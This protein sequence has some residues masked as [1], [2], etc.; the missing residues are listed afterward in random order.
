MANLPIEWE[1]KIN[2]PE[3]IAFLKQFGEKHYLSA[4]EINQLRDGINELDTNLNNAI[5]NFS[6]PTQIIKS[7]EVAI[8]GLNISV[9]AG[10]FAWK[11]NN[12]SFLTPP[13][14]SKTLDA[15]TT[16][17]YR[18]DLLQGNSD[19]TYSIK[20]SAES[21]SIGTPP[22]TDEGS[23]ALSSFL[24]FGE[25]VS[26][27]P[28]QPITGDIYLKKEY[29]T[30]RI[31]S[32]ETGIVDM[33]QERTRLYLYDCNSLEYLIWGDNPLPYH[34]M[35]FFVSN[36]NIDHRQLTIKHLSGSETG[37]FSFPDGQ[38]MILQYGELLHFKMQMPS[39]TMEYVGTD[40]KKADKAYVDVA[41]SELQIQVDEL[42]AKTDS[43]NNFK[44]IP[45]P[46]YTFNTTTRVL[47]MN[48]G[49]I[50]TINGVDYTNLAP[51]PF[52]AIP[53]APSGYS[54]ID[55]IVFKTDTTFVRIAGTPSTFTPVAPPKPTNTLQATFLTVGDGE[56]IVP[57]TPKP[58]A[59]V[60]SVNGMV[61]AV[62]IPV[63]N[64]I[65]TVKTILSTA[66]ATQNVA[67]FVTYINTLNPILVVGATE[68]VEYQL[69]DTGRLFK[70]L[71]R[72]RS[73]GV[74]Q[75]AIVAADVEE[76]T[77]WMAK[78]LK[79]SNYPNTRN[80]GSMSVNKFLSTDVNGNLKLYGMA[81]MPAP[82]LEEVIPDSTLPSETTAIRLKGSFFTPSM[83]I[84]FGTGCTITLATFISDNE[85]KLNVVTSAVEGSYACTLNNGTSATF[86]NS[87]LIVLGTVFKPISS[88]WEAP[89]GDID[90]TGGDEVRIKA[91]NLLGT[92]RWSHL[93]DYT[94]NF[95][96][97]MGFETT[98]F[99]IAGGNEYQVPHFMLV[100]SSDNSTALALN[101]RAE[102]NGFISLVSYTVLD[103]W[104]TVYTSYNTDQ[105]ISW[106]TFKAQNFQ[107]RFVGGV[108]KVYLNNALV[109]NFTITV[110]E[111]L[112][113]K[114][115][116]SRFDIIG[117]KYLET[118]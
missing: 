46:G 6:V 49:W 19:N 33:P 43:D 38:D 80:D 106:A 73:F 114:V 20:S 1:D 63:S 100:K 74:G 30:T 71:L 66:L 84:S 103:G 28:E 23:I 60:T 65:T 36:N 91:Y 104:R 99:G 51:Q 47:T 27:A 42:K 44:V 116:T 59:P 35:D 45:D 72:G 52:T 24:I 40:Y 29:Y 112:K 90:V 32:G 78:D 98:P 9:L 97:T 68:I 18:Y 64:T 15:A 81:V 111:N 13:A 117:I 76:I 105:L 31:A 48:A 12:V 25:L 3:L 109:H 62:V 2:S 21:T 89:T 50:G 110:A 115:S 107:I 94:K 67:G 7:S 53:L 102:G 101:V 85:V 22:T 79:L 93:L 96:V 83:T 69:S 39:R 8:D 75:A 57:V 88:E 4:E 34:G 37:R 55:L 118:A 14:Y 92:N 54:R 41:D 70:L 108:L 11:I 86:P 61:G 5:E 87:L 26:M 16:G 58:K 17:H 10:D 77:L 56:I 113:I 82:F 95:I